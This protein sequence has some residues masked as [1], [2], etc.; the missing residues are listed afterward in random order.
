MET[1]SPEW[2]LAQADRDFAEASG[3]AAELAADAADLLGAGTDPTRVWAG[4][5]D[6]L[7]KQAV[8]VGT[9]R[10]LHVVICA[11]AASCVRAGQ[12]RIELNRENRA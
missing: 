6:L 5:A 12:H 1:P 4:I 7:D 8:D 9:D 11:L 3:F 10:A 2:I